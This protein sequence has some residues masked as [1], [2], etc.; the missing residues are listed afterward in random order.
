MSYNIVKIGE[1]GVKKLEQL[2]IYMMMMMSQNIWR[3]KIE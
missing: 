3:R 2:L 1:E